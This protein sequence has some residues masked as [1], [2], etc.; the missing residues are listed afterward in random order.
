LVETGTLA[1]E[2]GAYR[3]TRPVEALQVPAT[4]QTILAARIDRLPAE[5][6]RLLQAASVI[7]KHVPYALLAAIAKQPEEALRGGLAHLQ[8]AEFL[9]ET[10]IFPDLE[11]TF[12]H[13]L[14]HEVAYGGLLHE[15]QR[16]LH[17]RITEAIERLSTGRLAEQAERLAHHAL[18][19]ELWEKAVTYL[20]QAGL[21]AMARGANREAVAHLEQALGTIRHLPEIRQT[22]ELT[23]DIHI[24]VRTALFPL[25][26]WVRMGDHLQEADGLART[27]GD[28]RRLARVAA[29]MVVKCQL[30][31]DYDEALRF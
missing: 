18:R 1:G 15:R 27:L 29:F 26:D 11:F 4:V 16:N 6:K 17:A 7:G 12:K 5:E 21:R 22:T 9:H 8:E 10:Q 28:Q 23:I 20:R 25:G 3:L 31:G 19:G 24:D 13:A 30:T 2:R 14:T